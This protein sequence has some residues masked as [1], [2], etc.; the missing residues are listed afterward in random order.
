MLSFRFIEI[1]FYFI[2]AMIVMPFYLIFKNDFFEDLLY[3]LITK[4]IEF[5][6]SLLIKLA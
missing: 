3:T 2:P 6:G 4:G 1:C 5:S